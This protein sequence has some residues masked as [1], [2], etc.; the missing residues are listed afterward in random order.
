MICNKCGKEVVD[1]AKF[2]GSCGSPV[3]EISDAVETIQSTDVNNQNVYSASNE[4]KDSLAMISLILGIVAVI[5]VFLSMPIG[6]FVAVVG[7][8]LALITKIRGKVRGF[9]IGLNIAVIFI[10][11]VAFIFNVVLSPETLNQLYN[12]LDYSTSD[13]YITGTWNCSK[14]D[15]SGADKDYSV[16]M[17]L[18]SDKSFV[19]GQY[20]DLSNNHAGG[21]YTFEDEKTKN[22]N[23]SN[24]YKYFLIDMTG[25]SDDYIVDGVKQ[26]RSFNAKF[27]IGI[28]SVNTKKE[29]IL[30]NYYTYQMYYC[31][32]EK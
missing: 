15:G 6:I 4:K 10:S 13:N 20:G 5:L 31:Y 21:T 14:F 2:C 26:D 24:G 3:E 17:K 29:A 8:I 1:G 30:M 16:T 23:T 12:E 18:N 27:E 19:F 11:A 7:L 32:L 9:G 25:N 22:E 28:T